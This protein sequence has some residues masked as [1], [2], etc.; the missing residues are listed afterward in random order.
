MVKNL[1][2]Y[3][4][5]TLRETSNELKFL[6]PRIP[7]FI[8]THDATLANANGKIDEATA[9]Q[10]HK[11][12]MYVC[13]KEL[14][15]LRQDPKINRTIFTLCWYLYNNIANEHAGVSLANNGYFLDMSAITQFVLNND[16]NYVTQVLYQYAFLTD[17][18]LM[19]TYAK[20]HSSITPANRNNVKAT[21]NEILSQPLD[22]KLT[23]PVPK[24][25]NTERNV[26]MNSSFF[27][28][29]NTKQNVTPNRLHLFDE[30][31]RNT[32]T[33]DSN[34]NA[35]LGELLGTYNAEISKKTSEVNQAHG[36]I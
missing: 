30:K 15:T 12:A 6:D 36:R 10:I 5:V 11:N 2:S 1:P 24:I 9:T 18:L 23:I 26:G 25:T 29:S 16:K 28:R 20:N 35:F 7:N 19:D 33:A 21:I 32:V 31:T 22:V 34:N 3:V 8:Y 17:V 14:A 27:S 13:K 4:P